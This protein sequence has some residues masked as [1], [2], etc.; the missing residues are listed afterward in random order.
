MPVV[1]LSPAGRSDAIRRITGPM[2]AH[3]R[4]SAIAALLCVL[5]ACGLL[6]M[7]AQAAGPAGAVSAPRQIDLQGHRGARGLWP[8]N[9]LEG[10][11]RT[12]DLGVS[13]LEL[14]VVATRDGVLVVHHDRA[15]NPDLTR[16]AAGR[17]LEAPAPTVISLSVAEVQSHDVGRLRPGTRYAR[18]FAS[19]QPID[20][21]RI[22]RLADLFRLVRERGDDRVRFAIE[23]KLS[24]LSPAEAPEPEAF[25]RMLM[26]EIAAAGLLQ[27]VQ[28]L[29]FDWRTLQSV[30]RSHPGVP[31]VYLTAQFDAMD[32]VMARSGRDSPWVAGFTYA[33]HGS[34]PRMIR[35]A[36]GTHWSSFWRELTPD[37]VREAQTLG[38]KVLAWTVN[39]RE[40]MARLL[41]MGI[42]GLVTDRPD[43][44]IGLLRER[45]IAW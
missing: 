10:F 31:T 27:R 38:L 45:G 19:Q 15:L 2:I 20:G 32:T 18:T 4:V 26:D 21:A 30:Q 3:G 6:P 25:A 11:A 44:A 42:D 9:T 1:S 23:T 34:I 28:I 7:S 13:T 16:D 14:D 24:P 35:A 8:E 29:S 41:D 36:G 39:E 5:I 22:P 43:I 33:R 12:L 17:Y 37:L 40:A